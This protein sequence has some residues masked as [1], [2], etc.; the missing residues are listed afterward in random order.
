MPDVSGQQVFERWQEEQPA[1]TRRVVFIT[2]DIVSADLQQF[3]A[4]TGQPFIAKPFDLD[5]V[6]RVLEQERHTG[7]SVL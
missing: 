2:G 1:L 5:V 4:S 3:L 6:L 7:F